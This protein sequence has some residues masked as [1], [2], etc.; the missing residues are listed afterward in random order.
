MTCKETEAHVRKDWPRAQWREAG[1]RCWLRDGWLRQGCPR[2]G[3]GGCVVSIKSWMG[4][5]PLGQ[6]DQNIPG[7]ATWCLP[8][9]IFS[10]IRRS[11]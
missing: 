6:W 5:E 11:Q 7:P 3:R 10:T 4:P 1:L 2:K 8:V 9:G